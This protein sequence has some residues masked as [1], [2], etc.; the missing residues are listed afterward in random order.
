MKK[1]ARF[2][3]FTVLPVRKPLRRFQ[4]VGIIRFLIKVVIERL[5]IIHDLC[6]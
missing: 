3:L 4:N 1:C 5:S 6:F 2:A